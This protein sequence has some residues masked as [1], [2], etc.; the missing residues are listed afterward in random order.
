LNKHVLVLLL[1]SKISLISKSDIRY[2]GLL[3]II[4]TNESTVAL[5]NGKSK[6]D[7]FLVP[8]LLEWSP[9]ALWIH[10]FLLDWPLLSP[11]LPFPALRY[12][13]FDNRKRILSLY[14]TQ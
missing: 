9:L 3:Y 4:N 11:P 7:D 10:G 12:M 5:Q 13:Y 2:E 8:L 6:D 1:G 14:F